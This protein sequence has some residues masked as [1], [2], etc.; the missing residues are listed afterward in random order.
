MASLPPADKINDFIKEFLQFNGYQ[1]TLECLQAE[2][3][4]VKVTAQS[5]KPSKVSSK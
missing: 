2:E 4:M 5:V 1:N 3:R